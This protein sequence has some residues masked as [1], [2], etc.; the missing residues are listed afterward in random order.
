MVT[1]NIKKEAETIMILLRK[2]EEAVQQLEQEVI[3][4]MMIDDTED[5]SVDT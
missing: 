2:L 5:N 4:L 1:T 3:S